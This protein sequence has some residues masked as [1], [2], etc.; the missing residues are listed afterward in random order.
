MKTLGLGLL[1]VTLVAMGGTV[2]RTGGGAGPLAATHPLPMAPTVSS[3]AD[4]AALTPAELTA[5][6]QKY[7]VVCHNDQLLTGNLSLQKLDVAAPLDHAETAEKMIVKL[8]AGMMPPP[9]APRPG[10]DTLLAL[11][12]TLEQTLDKAAARNPNPGQRTFQRLNR[13]EYA[14]SVQDLLGLEIDAA[15]F[16]PLDT[17]S[18]NFDNIADVQMLSPTLMNAYLRA[19][20]EISRMAV[21]VPDAGATSITYTNSGYVSQWERVPG[22][23]RGTR[24]GISVVHNFPADGEYTL[25]M[26]F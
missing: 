10:P 17:K 7:C 13:A 11:V 4:V 12:E 19:A 9:G 24:G 21:G 20:D 6:V 15:K 26:W 18:A 3:H 22:A 2:A 25:Q 5:V 14:A 8:R 16:L 23:P 1:G